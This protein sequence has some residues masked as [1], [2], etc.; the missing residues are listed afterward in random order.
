[1][2]SLI[3]GIIGGLV[4]SVV[5]GIVALVQ[6]RRRPYRGRGLA[7]GGLAASASWVLLFVLFVA[8]IV[9]DDADRD[10]DGQVTNGATVSTEQLRPGDCVN[11]L[12]EN[13]YM[14]SDLPAV[15][16]AEPHE[17]EVYAVVP[18]PEGDWPGK[19]EVARQAEQ[20]CYVLLTRYAT[21]VDPNLLDVF[22]LAP[23]ERG[24]M[25]GDRD[26]VCIAIDPSGKR[27]GSIGG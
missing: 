6:I 20:S 4:L 5:F 8:A 7:I 16:C 18:L 2:A 24:W 15:S 25:R 11:D 21:A 19:R 10:A 22:Y 27:T 12:N 1:M 23:M 13:D 9:M 17:G 3:L 14:V 26:I